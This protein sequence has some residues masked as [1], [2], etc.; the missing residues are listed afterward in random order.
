MA[1][2]IIPVKVD[3]WFFSTLRNI[4]VCVASPA[5]PSCRLTK[6]SQ[7][8]IE[9]YRKSPEGNPTIYVYQANGR[10]FNNLVVAQSTE[11]ATEFP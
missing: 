7:K 9:T 10:I 4:G 11:S 2:E 1:Y 6:A 3:S 5:G 8:T